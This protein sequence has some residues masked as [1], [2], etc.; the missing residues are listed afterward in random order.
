MLLSVVFLFVFLGGIFLRCMRGILKLY[1]YCLHSML[2][3]LAFVNFFKFCSRC[4]EKRIFG[5]FMN[6]FFM[7]CFGLISF[8]MS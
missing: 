3:C 2:S 4:R 6:N 1:P 7:L 8:F 5:T